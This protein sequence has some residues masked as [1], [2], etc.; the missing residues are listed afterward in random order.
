MQTDKEKVMEHSHNDLADMYLE[1][2]DT[3][4]W[5]FT[6]LGIA[7]N[8]NGGELLLDLSL[9]NEISGR[10]INFNVTEKEGEENIS[11]LTMEI[12]PNDEA[13]IE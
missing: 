5:L 9:M 3:N 4:R 13:V 2:R 1:L 6:T 8:T 12:V 10:Y 7:L 11:V